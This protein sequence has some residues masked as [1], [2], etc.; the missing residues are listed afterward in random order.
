M[1]S[2]AASSTVRIPNTEH[3]NRSWD[4]ISSAKKT[5]M[6]RRSNRWPTPG[7]VRWERTI[8]C[9]LHA[10]TLAESVRVD[11]VAVLL[12]AR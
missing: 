4:A 8:R 2:Y 5:S 11:L 10:G 9:R 12:D 7:G 1:V 6:D 3:P